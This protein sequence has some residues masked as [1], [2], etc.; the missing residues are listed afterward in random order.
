MSENSVVIDL[1]CPYFAELTFTTAIVSAG[2]HYLFLPNTN[3]SS[4]RHYPSP[5]SPHCFDGLPFESSS[6]DCLAIRNCDLEVDVE[7]LDLLVR[8]ADIFIRQYKRRLT[9]GGHTDG[10]WY[11]GRRPDRSIEPLSTH[12]P[13]GQLF[14]AGSSGEMS[15]VSVDG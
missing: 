14:G 6:M 2:S 13:K 4:G 5:V 3:R 15:S 1:L 10:T 12:R 11:R 9:R 8:Q 7:A